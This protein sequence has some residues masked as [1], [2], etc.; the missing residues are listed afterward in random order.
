MSTRFVGDGEKSPVKTHL[1]I[2]LLSVS[3]TLSKKE[4]KLKKIKK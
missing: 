4:K 1:A 3:K 2:D